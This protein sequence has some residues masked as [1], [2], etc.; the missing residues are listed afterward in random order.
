[1]ENPF[2]DQNPAKEDKVQSVG[3]S[4][5]AGANPSSPVGGLKKF[6]FRLLEFLNHHQFDLK[7]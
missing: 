7:F 2:Q 3:V 6:G 5:Q 1:M 4:T